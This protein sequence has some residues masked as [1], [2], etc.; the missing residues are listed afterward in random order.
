MEESNVVESIWSTI[1]VQ[2]RIINVRWNL[3]NHV[4]G[5]EWLSMKL[6]IFVKY[7]YISYS[8]YCHASIYGLFILNDWIYPFPLFLLSSL[9]NLY[10]FD[11]LVNFLVNFIF[12]ALC[13]RRRIAQFGSVSINIESL[14]KSEIG[15]INF[16]SNIT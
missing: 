1:F 9:F 12:T 16:S 11:L 13:V 2:Q 15:P 14:C 8:I 5:F 10:T 6:L 4:R 3:T 7:I